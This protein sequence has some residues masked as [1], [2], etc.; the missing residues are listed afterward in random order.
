LRGERQY[1]RDERIGVWGGQP[2]RDEA[3][4]VEPGGAQ[5]EQ[6]RVVEGGVVLDAHR[7]QR[8]PHERRLDHYAVLE[9]GVEVGR[10]ERGQPIPQGE[11]RRRGLLRLQPDHPVDGV[12]HTHRLAAQQ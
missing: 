8:D 2:G 9:C 3:A 1:V 6:H 12:D 4:V 7:V 11:V 5:G 10:V